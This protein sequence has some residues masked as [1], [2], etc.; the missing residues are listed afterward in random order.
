MWGKVLDEGQLG[1][2][3]DSFR[4][5][6]PFPAKLIAHHEMFD[7]M[8]MGTRFIVQFWEAYKKHRMSL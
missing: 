1:Q 3:M 8:F 4:Y 2:Y 5:F 6:I 7:W